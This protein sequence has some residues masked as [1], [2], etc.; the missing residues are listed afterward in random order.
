[1][2]LNLEKNKG[3]YELNIIN[4]NGKKEKFDYIKFINMLYEGNKVENIKY[5]QDIT[6]EEQE[7]IQSMID[8]IDVV[9]NKEKAEN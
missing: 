6:K 2:Q 5:G 3:I 1:M 9:V 4:E 8:K 7:Q